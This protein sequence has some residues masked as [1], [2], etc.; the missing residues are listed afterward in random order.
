LTKS[1]KA[2]ADKLVEIEAELTDLHERVGS[3]WRSFLC[4]R[5]SPGR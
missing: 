4:T 5:I 2:S 3:A 1:A